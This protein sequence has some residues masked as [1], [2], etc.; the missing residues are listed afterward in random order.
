MIVCI[1][2]NSLVTRK[3]SVAMIEPMEA[4]T[5]KSME[6]IKKTVSRIFEKFRNHDNHIQV[7]FPPFHMLDLK[8]ICSRNIYKYFASYLTDHCYKTK[9]ISTHTASPTEETIF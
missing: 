6:N 4:G 2:F 1:F 9:I 3:M 8:T 5:S 7:L